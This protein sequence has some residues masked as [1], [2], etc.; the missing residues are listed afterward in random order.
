MS[1]FCSGS[2][3]FGSEGEDPGE[4]E[5]VGLRARDFPTVKMRGH[6]IP[7]TPRRYQSQWWADR[8]YV[9]I[10]PRPTKA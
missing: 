1:V 8:A 3:R 5:E 4:K 2:G 10:F 6:V 7:R 9:A